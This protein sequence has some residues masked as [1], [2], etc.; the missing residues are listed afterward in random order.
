MKL[1]Y[2]S[3]VILFISFF[4]W[5]NNL[6][7]AQN[8]MKVSYNEAIKSADKYYNQKDYKNAKSY[9]QIA[10]KAKPGNEYAKNRIRE[11][12]QKNR[13]VMEKMYEYQDQIDVADGFYNKKDYA[14]AIQEYQ[15]AL[16]MR[17]S[18][19]YPKDRIEESKKLQEQQT[20]TQSKY[21]T[22][23]S[24]AEAAFKNKDYEKAQADFQ[25]AS[26]VIPAESYPKEKIKE[27]KQLIIKRD[28]NR[29]LYAEAMR[30]ANY[31]FDRKKYAES[32]VEFENAASLFPE[33]KEPQE[34]LAVL[35]E[36]I[37]KQKKVDTTLETA[38]KFYVDKEF[39]KSK[40]LYEEALRISPE[41][42]YPKEMIA[43][44]NQEL[45][46]EEVKT[47]EEYDKAIASADNYFDSKDYDN[48]R[49]EYAMASS[50]KPESAYPKNKLNEIDNIIASERA[51]ADKDKKY[52]EYIAQGDKSFDNNE[53]I[54][55]KNFY[56]SALKLRPNE[57]HPKTRLEEIQI[58]LDEIEANI[59]KKKKFDIQLALA[60]GHYEKQEYK[61]A[62]P[63]Y[64]AALEL[65]PN[66][67]F[68]KKRIGEVN[69]FL[70]QQAQTKEKE[71][72][73]KKYITE[74]DQLLTAKKYE[75]AKV[76]YNQAS[77]LF[78]DRPYPQ[79]KI[80]EIDSIL[81]R[82]AKERSEEENYASAIKQA[83]QFLASKE[84]ESAKEMYQKASVIFADKDYPK[85][86]I[87][88]IETILAEQARIKALED[89]YAK[90]VG[91]GENFLNAE[92]YTQALASFKKAQ[93]IKPDEKLPQEKIQLI[94]TKLEEI[95]QQ[96]AVE[97]EFND[98]LQ[99]ADQFYAE[100][101]FQ[102]ALDSYN[103]ALKLKPTNELVL[104]K[105]TEVKDA[106]QKQTQQAELQKQF[107]ET[108][109]KA[110]ELFKVDNYKDALIA[111]EK[112]NEIKPE[113]KYPKSQINQI[114]QKLEEIERQRKI[115]E[116]YATA[117]KKGDDLLAAD[118]WA[119][120]RVSYENALSIKPN[121]QYPQDKI[122]E[123]NKIMEEKKAEIEE[124][125]NQSIAKAD[126]FLTDKEYQKAID[127]YTLA[128]SLKPQETYPKLKINE[129]E[130]ALEAIMKK[131]QEEYNQ[132]IGLADNYYSTKSYDKALDYYSQAQNIK[133]DETY[134]TDMIHKITKFLEENAII[135][136][137]EGGLD[138]AQG[139]TK[140]FSFTPVPTT[141]RKSNFL[142]VR[143][144]NSTGKNLKVQIGYG[145]DKTKNGGTV[146]TVP[147][148][149][150]EQDIL[151]RIGNQYK[152]FSN[153]NNW[154][155]FYAQNGSVEIKLV[156]IS[157]GE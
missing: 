66:N 42:S 108:I 77:T 34:K 38:D 43:K 144:V 130:K 49:T 73:Y 70:Q 64:Q 134:P 40:A 35:P 110:D 104:Q 36:L 44:I 5:N 51:S 139:T 83:D 63:P 52:N 21:D 61:E 54:R 8:T 147:P 74:A 15:K 88:E 90:A 112:A 89:N 24:S 82:L 86:K 10:L 95:A 138:I 6:I 128:K 100:D 113:E 101:A 33:E 114:N 120:A 12:I 127:N 53:L 157:K 79:N 28:S 91:D 115:E 136:I 109:A 150:G 146:I 48:A 25:Q 153:D 58:A 30:K 1:K 92:D 72:Q 2:L 103:E 78:N 124:K 57:T 111:Y 46:G 75:E 141:L 14:K 26:K 60:N 125:Y 85:S 13:V 154:L 155:S 135:S 67:A 68:V 87:Q 117:I 37:E 29:K 137:D 102:K 116:S 62:L 50:L 9:Y 106:L 107:D 152:W 27:I 16:A 71:G 31:L 59:E 97:K 45:K 65:F 151:I 99:K 23:V 80:T 3:T 56:E 84:Y 32:K 119:E 47:D 121:E 81:D 17:P 4:L 7:L 149:E 122:A 93:D 41:D 96:K 94:N 55:S 39:R 148:K 105:I 131:I 11:S 69:D 118:N 18:E 156:Q 123:I 76:I 129:A 98:W 143:L 145:K 142:L 132:A 126:Q 20:V 133:K 22:F 140:K 19:K